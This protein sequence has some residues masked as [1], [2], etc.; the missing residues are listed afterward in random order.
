MCLQESASEFEDSEGK[1]F[2]V[3]FTPK[4]SAADV[5]PRVSW[6]EK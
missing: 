4:F 5:K 2:E 6:K 1:T 3:N